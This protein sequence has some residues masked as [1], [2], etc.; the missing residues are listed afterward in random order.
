MNELNAPKV[1]KYTSQIII[2]LTALRIRQWIK[3]FIVLLPLVFVLDQQW[4]YSEKTSLLITTLQAI[5]AFTIFC[6]LSSGTYLINDLFDL[7][8]DQRHPKKQY[9]PI[10]S[11]ALSP[12]YAKF[13]AT[14]LI[15]LGLTLSSI[16]N[17]NFLIIAITYVIITIAYSK[18]FK[19]IAWVDI[20]ILISGYLLRAMAGAS[21]LEAPISIWLY[22]IVGLSA[23]LIG[24][25]KRKSEIE[26]TLLFSS[27]QVLNKYNPILLKRLIYLI[28]ILTITSYSLYTLLAKSLPS[29]NT[30]TITIPIAG[31][32]LFRY[33]KIANGHHIGESPEEILWKDRAIKIGI[34]LWLISTICILYFQ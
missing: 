2:F 15:I 13:A 12:S 7:K 18:I 21:A 32:C 1:Q 17:N 28:S 22:V 33:L 16:L 3:N 34:F 19:H 29:N 8:Y 23:T 4:S 14:V 9:R 25:I 5:G 30:M 31:Y 6:L 26:N 20:I 27:R 11:G 24:L 10:A